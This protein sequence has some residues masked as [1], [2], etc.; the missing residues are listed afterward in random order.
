VRDPIDVARVAFVVAAIAYAAAGGSG[1]Q[2]VAVTSVAVL[3]VRPLQLPRPYDAS[4]VLAM[5][6]AGWGEALRLYDRF[7]HFDVIVHTLVPLLGAPILYVFLARIDLVPD[8][9]DETSRRHHAGI[10]V[11]TVALGLALGAL[12]ELLEYASDG[13]FGS[14]LQLGLRDTMGDLVADGVGAAAGAALLV[15][16]AVYGWGTVRRAPAGA[17]GSASLAAARET[18]GRD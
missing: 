8:P 17:P 15:V 10:F 6:I 14:D 18:A 5:A 16:W 4:F 1:L 11:V 9:A 13:L 3:A 7:A 12:W 2:A